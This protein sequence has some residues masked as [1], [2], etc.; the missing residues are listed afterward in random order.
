M[1][2]IS[3]IK[4]Q[5]TKENQKFLASVRKAQKNFNEKID[6]ILKNVLEKEILKLKESHEEEL[7]QLIKVHEKKINDLVFQQ[8]KNDFGNPKNPSFMPEDMQFY[9]YN[10]SPPAYYE[11]TSRIFKESVKDS[12]DFSESKFLK[13]E[14]IK[15]N[16]WE[17][18]IKN[19]TTSLNKIK[20]MELRK[21]FE[22][23]R[24]M[25]FS[26]SSSISSDNEKVKRN[27]KNKK[28]LKKNKKEKESSFCSSSD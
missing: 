28:K 7:N 17:N 23:L 11:K 19:D 18:N 2:S 16:I 1:Q 22:K 26:S 27:K 25:E 4:L 14:K 12:I 5:I 13:P 15:K 20:E 21:R 8:E 9:S 6:N 24:M 10:D 3:S